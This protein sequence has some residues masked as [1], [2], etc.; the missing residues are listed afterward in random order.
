MQLSCELNKV[1]DSL[2]LIEET[3]LA[4]QGINKNSRLRIHYIKLMV[5][6]NIMRAFITHYEVDN[7]FVSGQLALLET[8]KRVESSKARTWFTADKICLQQAFTLFCGVMESVDNQQ[9]LEIMQYVESNSGDAKW[10][11]HAKK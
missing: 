8:L 11:V 2:L 5:M 4:V 9:L 10:L 1:S 3:R 6:N 7:D